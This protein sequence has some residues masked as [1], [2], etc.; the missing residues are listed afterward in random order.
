MIDD[1]YRCDCVEV[2]PQA[3]L[4]N[5]PSLLVSETDTVGGQTDT[6][7]SQS[8]TDSS[9]PTGQRSRPEDYDDIC[10]AYWYGH[11]SSEDCFAIL[12]RI[13][14]EKESW[15]ASSDDGN[16]EDD[17]YWLD[18]DGEGAYWFHGEAAPAPPPQSA[19]L[20]RIQLPKT[21][22][23][24]WS[25]AVLTYQRIDRLTNTGNCMTTLLFPNSQDAENF[26]WE[27]VYAEVWSVIHSCVIGGGVG[28][29]ARNAG[30]S[31]V[32]QSVIQ[33]LTARQA[34]R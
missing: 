1:C 27:F 14:L 4:V 11:P 2:L 33:S 16:D 26:K 30:A 19:N 24:G 12:E 23:S 15:H 22:R 6:Q 20:P 3:D 9:P 32:E 13:R 25:R 29:M 28:G 31:E 8:E 18:H 7:T 21:Y 34:L 5:D 10:S 17:P